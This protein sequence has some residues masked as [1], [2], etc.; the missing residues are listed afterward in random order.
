MRVPATLREHAAPYSKRNS[1]VAV[2]WSALTCDGSDFEVKMLHHT[3]V[4]PKDAPR[5]TSRF[6]W[7]EFF[8]EMD[9]LAEGKRQ[10]GTPAAKDEDGTEWGVILLF[11]KGDMEQLVK[12][13]HRDYGGR[14]KICSACDGDTTDMPFTDL[15]SNA[16][17]R[18]TVNVSNAV[19]M[20]RIAR[21]HPVADSHYFNKYFLRYDSMHIMDLNGVTSV[22]AGSTIMRIVRHDRDL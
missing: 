11:G 14:G 19:Y 6:A 12:W 17:W 20:S 7:E 18:P 10:D 4:R 9:A 21:G 2:T 16:K 8:K 15:R 1:A 5:D 22:A 3:E 13:G